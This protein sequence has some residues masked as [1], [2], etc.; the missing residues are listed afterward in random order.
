MI[1]RIVRLIGLECMFCFNH[2]I[3]EFRSG[4]TKNPIYTRLSARKIASYFY[5]PNLKKIYKTRKRTAL[6]MHNNWLYVGSIYPGSSVWLGMQHV[7]ATQDA[8]CVMDL[9]VV[10]FSWAACATSQLCLDVCTCFKTLFF[11]DGK[12]FKIFR[13]EIWHCAKN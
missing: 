6:H 7:A 1:T 11:C 2:R 8:T 4:S 13:E 12:V 9:F 5:S 10:P 3:A